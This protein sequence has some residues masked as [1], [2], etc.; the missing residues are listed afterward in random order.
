MKKEI[1]LGT[2]LGILSPMLVLILTWGITITV[3][4]ETGKSRDAEQ[5]RL[6]KS[7]EEY[8]EKV[9]DRTDANYR[10]ILS[11]LRTIDDKLDEKQDK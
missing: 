7:N 11:L 5:D 2:L 8:I 3:R 9:A 1:T 6:I 4:M 10:E